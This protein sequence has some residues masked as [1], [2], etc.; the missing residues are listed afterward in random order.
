MTKYIKLWETWQWLNREEEPNEGER[1]YSTTVEDLL[2]WAVGPDWAEDWDWVPDTIMIDWDWIDD[3]EAIGY[4]EKLKSSANLEIQAFSEESDDS[5]ETYWQMGGITWV[6][7]S[8]DWPFNE[9][10]DLTEEEKS[11]VLKIVAEVKPESMGATTPDVIDWVLHQ[12]RKLGQRPERLTSAGFR[13][14]FELGR[15]GLN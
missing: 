13:N 15:A 12:V 9:D 3:D 7:V 4:H 1:E 5:I 2:T 14:W 8:Q 10:E 6:I 11:A